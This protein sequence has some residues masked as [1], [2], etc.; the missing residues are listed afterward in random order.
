MLELEMQNYLRRYHPGAFRMTAS[1][2][3]CM[4][5]CS[6]GWAFAHPGQARIKNQ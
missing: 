4:R 1:V 3:V 2:A 5:P 6:L